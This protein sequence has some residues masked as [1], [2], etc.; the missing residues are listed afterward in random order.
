MENQTD[1]LTRLIDIQLP[2]DPAF[3][4][5]APGWWIAV[6]VILVV[7]YFGMHTLLKYKHSKK[8]LREF[9]TK[10]ESVADS[11]ESINNS[12]NSLSRILKQYTIHCY[13]REQVARLSGSDWL[14]F[15]DSKTTSGNG[16]SSGIGAS[17]GDGLYR[18]NARPDITLLKQFL[19]SWAHGKI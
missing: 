8:P 10:V 1:P 6:L 9:V 7:L 3:W 4:P 11:P 2:P 18:N 15:L 13:G 14:E 17:L 19:I 12:L 16:F 5:P